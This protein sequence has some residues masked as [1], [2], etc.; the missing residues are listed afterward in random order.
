MDRPRRPP[1]AGRTNQGRAHRSQGRRARRRPPGRHE[2]L[3]LGRPTSLDEPPG[4]DPRAPSSPD[5]AALRQACRRG[6]LE[7]VPRSGRPEV[8]AFSEI[9][10]HRGRPVSLAVIARHRGQHVGVCV[11]CRPH[12]RVPEHLHHGTSLQRAR[13]FSEAV[14]ARRTSSASR[15]R[16]RRPG[17]RRRCWSRTGGACPHSWGAMAV[18]RRADFRAWTRSMAP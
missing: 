16:N 2:S 14:K 17:W 5:R 8:L 12:L 10:P 4:R 18:Q 7:G 1:R 6:V 9:R 11:R 15:S 3:L 13:A